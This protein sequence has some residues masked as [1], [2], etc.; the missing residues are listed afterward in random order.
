MSMENVQNG[1]ERNLLGV[2]QTSHDLNSNPTA[3]QNNEY[4]LTRV[5]I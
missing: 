5:K 3:N 1:P 4:N 2:R